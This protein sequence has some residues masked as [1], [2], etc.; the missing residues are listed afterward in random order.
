MYAKFEIVTLNRR[1]SFS[2]LKD[3]LLILCLL[4]MA[5]VLAFTRGLRK[6]NSICINNKNSN[7]FSNIKRLKK[8]SY[9][10]L[11]KYFDRSRMSRK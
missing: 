10:W 3:F 11:M 8:Q 5:K 9:T 1:I 7:L 4:H 2:Y 6:D